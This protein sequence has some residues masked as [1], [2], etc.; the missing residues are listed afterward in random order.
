MLS[1]MVGTGTESD[2]KEAQ[3]FTIRI[4]TGYRR[5]ALAIS[6]D[7]NMLVAGGPKGRLWAINVHSGERE[8]YRFNVPGDIVS[9]IPLGAQSFIMGSGRGAFW[10]EKFSEGYY[11]HV[12]LMRL[13][14]KILSL[15]QLK[16]SC[17]IGYGTHDGAYGAVD[18]LAEKVSQVFITSAAEPACA[19]SS[20]EE[21]L[22][23]VGAADNSVKLFDMRTRG[24]VKSCEGH[25][26]LV[27]ALSASFD[28][29][30]FLSG[31]HDGRVALWNMRLGR[32]HLDQSIADM[33]SPVIS[34]SSVLLCNYT[35]GMRAICG[36][37][38]G[39][40]MLVDKSNEAISVPRWHDAR[41][42]AVA[43]GKT[44]S[45]TTSYD[46]SVVMG[47]ILSSALLS[48]VVAKPEADAICLIC[49][50]SLYNGELLGV[51]MCQH[52]YHQACIATAM[53]LKPEC[54]LRCP[55]FVKTIA[56][57]ELEKPREPEVVA[58]QSVVSSS[59]GGKKG[60]K[61][62]REE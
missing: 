48:A 8:R 53:A 47:G 3:S 18:V 16:N 20:L 25:A 62:A 59:V 40:A 12:K 51:L 37:L 42:T 5:T 60:K 35:Q 39:T 56:P 14:S 54:P 36:T 45:A 27:S 22:V 55:I 46:K 38:N 19:I 9:L 11:K 50:D 44:L 31:A 28:E 24:V 13:G 17:S 52:L 58:T 23:A 1:S 29:H 4:P 34:L 10:L 49:R 43:A 15:T 26:A 33:A 2:A 57:L 21:N 32:S 30:V 41:I 7:G 6:H 61:R